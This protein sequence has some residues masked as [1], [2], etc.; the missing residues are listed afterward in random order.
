MNSPVINHK[1]IKNYNRR[2]ILNLLS[3]KRELTRQAIS[4]KTGISLPTVASNIQEL[5][6]E[7]LVE[8]AGMAKS[9]S[10]RKPLI[11]RYL[12]DARVSF[13]M[14]FTPDKIRILLTNLDSEIRF[15]S[16][17]NIES[18]RNIDE[19]I[20][21]ISAEIE[22]ILLLLE[23]P[24]EKVLGI[25]FALPGTVNQK[26]MTLELAP[27]LGMK[28]ICF[29]PFES[30]FHYPVF[31]ENEANAGALAE[32]KLGK[33]S[34][35]GD[36]VYVAVARGVGAGII[37]H[38]KLYKGKNQR[39]GEFGHMTIVPGGKLCNC[40]S[41]GCWELYTS[42]NALMNQ[43]KEASGGKKPAA[44]GISDFLNLLQSNDPIAKSV[45]D[46]YL[47]YFALG[48]QNIMLGLDPQ[49]ILIGGEIGQFGDLLIEPLIQRVFKPKGFDEAGDVLITVSRLG[50][51]APTLGAALL[52]ILEYLD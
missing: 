9:A 38:G 23:I 37:I 22:R 11:V 26:K 7:G 2:K 3:A 12:P 19:I 16:E 6:K 13:G 17:L 29:K 15:E 1:A 14:E 31:I 42:E 44:F 8:D 28:D 49:L 34:K 10:G 32:L 4:L 47:D 39:A 27:N 40:G 43:Y 45:W 24:G 30:V 50:T 52:P 48:I 21:R 35:S 5:I 41:T 51:R 33:S 46:E 25:G 20:K 36:L 18:L